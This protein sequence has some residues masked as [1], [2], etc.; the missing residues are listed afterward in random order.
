M[1]VAW[2][3][4]AAVRSQSIPFQPE[5]VPRPRRV[6]TAYHGNDQAETYMVAIKNHLL[7]IRVNNP[8]CRR[9]LARCHASTSY[10]GTVRRGTAGA[11]VSARANNYG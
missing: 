8:A 1:G 11:R 5:L 10:F 9:L 7:L 2:G 3:P 6:R 4:D